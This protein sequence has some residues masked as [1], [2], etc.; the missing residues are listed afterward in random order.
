MVGETGVGL[1]LPDPEAVAGRG[2]GA[3]GRH[4]IQAQEWFWL[5]PT[6]RDAGRGAAGRS[7]E[8]AGG[9]SAGVGRAVSSLAGQDGSE[10]VGPAVSCGSP[11]PVT[12]VQDAKYATASLEHTHGRD[13]GRFT[14]GMLSREG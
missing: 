9:G 4:A 14:L 6:V 2:V 11:I 10:D 3:Q 1:L 12:L 13:Q 7:I 8:S 5:E